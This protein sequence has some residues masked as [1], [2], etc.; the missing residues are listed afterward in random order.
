[1]KEQTFS[2]QLNECRKSLE[3]LIA[4]SEQTLALMLMAKKFPH[5]AERKAALQLQCHRED[6]LRQGYQLRRSELLRQVVPKANQTGTDT[7]TP[8]LDTSPVH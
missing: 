2:K 8:G 1:V 6:R 7:P 4:E 3:A 5:D